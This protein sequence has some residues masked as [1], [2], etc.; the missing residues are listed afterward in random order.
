MTESDLLTISE[1]VETFGVSRKTVQ[2]WV[3]GSKVIP[4]LTLPGRTGAHLFSRE[5]AERAFGAH[6][7]PV[8]AHA[9]KKED[10]A[11]DPTEDDEDDYEPP[12]VLSPL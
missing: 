9:D 2:R 8:R 11:T 3:K 7:K 4:T 10:L 1:I 5:E 6:Q 12:A